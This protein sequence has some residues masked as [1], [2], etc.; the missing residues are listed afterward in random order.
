MTLLASYLMT[1][2]LAHF[3]QFLLP[4][5]LTPKPYAIRLWFLQTV[6]VSSVFVFYLL[7]TQRPILASI[8]TLALA[9]I[10][11]VINQAKHHALQEPF[12][13][14]DIFLYV[15]VVKHPRLFL[16]FL[17]IPLTVIAIISS[18][19]FILLAIYWEPPISK[20]V[21]FY[22][23]ITLAIAFSVIIVIHICK[24]INLTFDPHNDTKNLGFFNNLAI[25]AI[26]SNTSDQLLSLQAAIKQASPF[27][28]RQQQPSSKRPSV[29]Q[30]ADLIVIQSESFFDPRALC[31]TI[32]PTV[33]NQF[34]TAC[35]ESIQY[36]SLEVPAWGANTLR[37]EFAFLSGV[38]NQSL[39]H[40]RFNPYQYLKKEKT[41]TIASHLK[42]L[43]YRCIA[44]HPHHSS[45]FCRDKAFPLFGFDEFID[46]D[47]FDTNQTYGPYISD[48]AV[49][50]KISEIL[51]NHNTDQPLFIF[52]IT[53]ENHGPLHLEKTTQE[54][55]Q[56]LYTGETPEKHNDLTVYLRH[57]SNADTMLG[58]LKEQLKKRERHSVLG[59]YGDHVPSM[60]DI[61]KELGT[62]GGET[63]Y[64]YWSNMKGV[65]EFQQHKQN[66]PLSIEQLAPRLVNFCT[67]PKPL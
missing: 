10:L 4:R 39:K 17:N 58:M 11:L 48:Q 50:E 35:A 30:M 16:P 45:F 54:D 14:S 49:Q 3:S 38:N 61:Y 56:K 65:P 59:F 41:P 8:L 34:D 12:V 1:I 52:A 20:N 62:N 37:S 44:I 24:T 28:E 2:L 29:H 40:Y 23:S 18:I 43:G 53:M 66:V 26:Q 36:G 32:N 31:K 42:S 55:V 33:L 13:F 22:L 25:Y 57:L 47:D 67:K 5:N 46:I 19:T 15:Q 63:S 6:L 9:G 27:A 21:D 7:L 60:P 51:A 64:F